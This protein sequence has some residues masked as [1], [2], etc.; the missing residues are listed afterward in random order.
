MAK[1]TYHSLGHNGNARTKGLVNSGD[2]INIKSA[3]KGDIIDRTL[4]WLETHPPEGNSAW[5]TMTD[6]RGYRIGE[7]EGKTGEWL[8]VTDPVPK[9]SRRKGPPRRPSPTAP[10]RRAGTRKVAKKKVR[11]KKA[12]K[13]PSEPQFWHKNGWIFYYDGTHLFARR[14]SPGSKAFGP[15]YLLAE[16]ED[17]KQA[18]QHID[19]LEEAD[20]EEA[21]IVG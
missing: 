2:H 1:S 10:A 18:K 6:K 11:K 21:E 15:M 3:T 19:L 14:G 17:A 16:P 5:V 7:W 8:T 12:A 9:S 4:T 13:G 20:I